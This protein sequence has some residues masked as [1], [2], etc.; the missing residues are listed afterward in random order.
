MG[1]SLGRLRGRFQGG[2]IGIVAMPLVSGIRLIRSFQGSRMRPRRGNEVLP[3]SCVCREMAGLELVV[4]RELIQPDDGH[5]LLR[6]LLTSSLHG[7]SK[8]H[9]G[10]IEKSSEVIVPINAIYF[11]LSK[12]I[13]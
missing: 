4:F 6:C 10:A 7:K 3:D 8:P 13:A 9:P 12:M 5:G 2:R 1:G 11:K